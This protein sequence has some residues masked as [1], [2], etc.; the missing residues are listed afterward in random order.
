M[1]KRPS[2]RTTMDDKGLACK[3]D[4]KG[5]TQDEF[6]TKECSD[7]RIVNSNVR[8]YD[9]SE[10]RIWWIRWRQWFGSK[11]WTCSKWKD[12]VNRAGETDGTTDEGE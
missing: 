8:L 9:E 7:V 3:A 6:S 4:L 11:E 1:R 5:V 12:K 2:R 10:R